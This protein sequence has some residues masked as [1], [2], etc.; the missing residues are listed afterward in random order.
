MPLHPYLEY[1]VLALTSPRA[2]AGQVDDYA[3]GTWAEWPPTELLDASPYLTSI[4]DLM[5]H[6][7]R[8][9]LVRLL[10]LAPG[11]VI[12][13]HTDPT[14]GL[15]VE[16]SLIRLTV[17]ICT[18]D[19]V[20]FYLNDTLVPWQPGECWYLRFTDPHWAV[21]AGD[22]ERIHLS[23]DVEPNAS[24]RSLITA[25]ATAEPSVQKT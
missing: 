25:A 22:T 18:N 9:T 19:R 16:R 3:D 20:A 10:R 15:E 24:I 14:L 13:E 7:T 21:N 2:I 17:P 11:S 1:S 5:R 23:I 8:V 6:L 12:A 4:V